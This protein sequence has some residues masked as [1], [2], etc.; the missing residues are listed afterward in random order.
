MTQLLDLTTKRH[1]SR[2]LGQW[3][4]GREGGRER[5]G[6]QASGQ[7]ALQTNL[8]A[9]E[10]LNILG[11]ASQSAAGH[12]V[13]PE[14]AMRVSTVY[15]CVSLIA[16][17][18]ATLP[19]G[20]FERDGNTRKKADHEY[21]WLFN[22]QAND[23]MSAATAWEYL[24]AAKLLHGDGIAKLLR[25][26]AV[27]SRVIG[28]EPLDTTRVQPIKTEDG[29]V[30]YRHYRD[31][32]KIEVLQADDVVH[33]N[34]LGFDGLTSPSPITYAARE[35]IGTALASEE[36]SAKFFAQGATADIA[37]KTNSTLKDDQVNLLRQSWMA[38]YGGSKNSRMP[39]VL[40]GG[41]EVQ[42]LSINPV[43]AALLPTRLFTVEEICRIFGVPPHMVGHTEKNSSWGT[44]MEAQGANF[45][46]YTLLRHLVPL[47][48]ELNR[49]LWPT[50]ARFFVEHITAALERGDLKSRYEAYRIALGRAGEHPW[51]D[52]NEIRRIENMEPNPNLKPN[53][54]TSAPEPPASAAG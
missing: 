16:G 21:W 48:Q 15:A 28:W 31:D 37:L 24:I 32:G 18:I 9:N 43:D 46:R 42:T 39:L 33:L 12:S 30:V 11:I 45:V 41:L 3:L 52:A 20:I 27:S 44:G 2:V 25:P 35:A 47:A 51:L 8:S 34:S 4:A 19:L 40:S 10:L 29:H 36:F 7:N 1:E 50:R 53:G 13:T 54:G 23:N 5:A 22:E 49:K 38:K 6:V 14:T 17:A 26:S